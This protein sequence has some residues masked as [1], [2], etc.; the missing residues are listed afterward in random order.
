[1]NIDVSLF[2][3]IGAFLFNTAIGIYEALNFDFGG[4]T[5]NGWVLLVGVAVVFIVIWFLAR[6]FE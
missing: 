1:M 5:V 4:F 6:I 2:K 3:D